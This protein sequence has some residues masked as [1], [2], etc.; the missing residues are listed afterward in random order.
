MPARVRK[1]IGGLAILAFLFVYVGL[2]VVIADH[3]PNQWA[4]KLLFFGLAGVLWGVPLLP[5]IRWMNREP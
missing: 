3:V 4:V 5:L 2:V 1:L